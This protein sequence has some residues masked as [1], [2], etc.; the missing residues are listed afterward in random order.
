[1]QIDSTSLY[2]SDS[3]HNICG[4]VFSYDVYGLTPSEDDS[5]IISVTGGTQNPSQD[6]SL[7][8]ALC[9]LLQAYHNHDVNGIA[10][11]YRPVDAANVSTILAVDSLRQRYLSVVSLI[12]QMKLLFTYE[13]NDFTV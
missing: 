3:I 9:R 11:Q 1:M 8:A 7:P 12:Q 4:L 2:V 10:Q 13:Q 5:R 6:A